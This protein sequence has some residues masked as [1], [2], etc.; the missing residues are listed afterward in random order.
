MKV[1]NDAKNKR[2]RKKERRTQGEKNE[3]EKMKK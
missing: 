3:S 1:M 2:E